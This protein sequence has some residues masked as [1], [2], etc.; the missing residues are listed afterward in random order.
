MIDEYQD[1]SLQGKQSLT[2]RIIFQAEDRTLTDAEVNAD[3]EKIFKIL[4]SDLNA[5]IR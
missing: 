5:E 3:M 4:R 1:E 2:F